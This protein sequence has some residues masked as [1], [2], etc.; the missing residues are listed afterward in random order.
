M[1]IPRRHLADYVNKL[2]QKACRTC[3]TITF[4]HSTNQVI[5]HKNAF[6]SYLRTWFSGFSWNAIRPTSSLNAENNKVRCE[7]KTFKGFQP[8]NQSFGFMAW[9]GQAERWRLNSINSFLIG[10]KPTV[11]FRNQRPSKPADYTTIMSRSW[12]IMSCRTAVHD[13]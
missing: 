9:C 4:P 11:N 13:F 1:K 6:S 2:C 7:W 3:S 10:R 8:Q 5:L 12:V